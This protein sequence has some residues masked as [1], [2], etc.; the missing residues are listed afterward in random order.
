MSKKQPHEMKTNKWCITYW[1]TEGR[2]QDD[3]NA[4]T[5]NMP[6]NWKLEG[7]IEQGHDIDDKLHAQLMLHTEQ[8]RGTKIA[9]YFPS[10][11]IDEAKNP[12]A[13]KKYVHK[14]DTRVAEFK[15]VENR[16]PQWRVVRDKFFDWLLHREE[17]PAT[18]ETEYDKYRLWDEFIGQS[19][20]E[21][22]EVDLI[23][24][25]P[26]YRCCINKYWKNGINMAIKRQQ[27]PV[28]KKTDKTEDK[29]LDEVA[30][31]GVVPIVKKVRKLVVL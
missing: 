5:Q 20:E 1:L 15:T 30:E 25:N 8:T 16:S 3:L 12:F 4:M 6:S 29:V 11:F 31:G 28:D 21:G 27:T 14:Q 2:T 24:V 13:L 19:L 7:Q 26:Q 22:M 9:K 10:C 18:I 17:F 23:G